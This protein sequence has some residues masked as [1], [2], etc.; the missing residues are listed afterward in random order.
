MMT[1]RLLKQIVL[2]FFLMVAI[3]QISPLVLINDFIH[4]RGKGR[5]ICKKKKILKDDFRKQV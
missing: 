5:T 1:G 4:N 2:A 3:N